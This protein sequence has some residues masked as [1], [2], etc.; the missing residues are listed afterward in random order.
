MRNLHVRIP[1]KVTPAERTA[2]FL[3]GIVILWVPSLLLAATIVMR[4]PGTWPLSIPII[5][6]FGL[7]AVL[8][9]GVSRTNRVMLTPAA[10]AY[11][12]GW[13]GLVHLTRGSFTLVTGRTLT[14]I[15]SRAV[16]RS[17][18]VTEFVFAAILLF[19]AIALSRH[20]KGRHVDIPAREG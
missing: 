2:A 6:G 10:W 12:C 11:A 19:A 13:T 7:L 1:V 18:S 14:K 4:N 9:V 16:P 3:L 15:G 8:V 5:A 17:S 20:A